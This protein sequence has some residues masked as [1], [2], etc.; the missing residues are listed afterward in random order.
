CDR[1]RGCRFACSVPTV[2]AAG[3]KSEGWVAKRRQ[4]RDLSFS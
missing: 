1:S 2:Y 4:Q 3:K